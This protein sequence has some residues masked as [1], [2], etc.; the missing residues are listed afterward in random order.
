[1]NTPRCL[2]SCVIFLL[3][4]WCVESEGEGEG[5]GASKSAVPEDVLSKAVIKV[6]GIGK[7]PESKRGTAQGRLMAERAAEIVAK[8]NLGLALGKVSIEGTERDKEI[9]VSAFVRGAR[10]TG[11]KV[12]PDGSVEVTMELPLSEVARNFAEMQRLAIRAEE[13]RQKLEDAFQKTTE[14]LSTV[15]SKLDSVEDAVKKLETQL[16]SI[17]A[18]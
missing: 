1:M 12:L 2:T 3:L 5:S 14:E 7:A 4:A 11:K 9:F 6:T 18:Q 10:V 13:N 15:K 8:R 16:K 17:E